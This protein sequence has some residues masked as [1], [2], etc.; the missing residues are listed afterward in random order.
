MDMFL[1]FLIAGLLLIGA[2]IFVPG[3]ILGLIGGIMLMA[4][5]VIGFIQFKGYGGYIAIAIVLLLG[6][7]VY[8]WLHLFPKSPI[9]QRMTARRDLATAKAGDE[10]LSALVGTTGTASS[11][12]RPGGFATI[13]GK[14]IDVITRGEMI[15]R[16]TPV[17]VVKVEGSRVIVTEATNPPAA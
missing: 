6:C 9:G 10:T 13:Q 4:A 7:S 11:D 15:A 14:R 2:E 5:I 17:Q 3:G 1:I 16:N 8:L 12:L